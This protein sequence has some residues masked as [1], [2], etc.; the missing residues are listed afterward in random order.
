[1]ARGMKIIALVTGTLFVVALALQF[2]LINDTLLSITITLGVVFYHFAMRLFVGTGIDLIF[3]NEIDYKRA[4]F[5][6]KRFEKR[7]Y[8]ILRVRKWAKKVPTYDSDTFS[9]KKHSWEEILKAT[10]QSEI[11]HK[12]IIALSLLPILLIIP[13]GTPLVFILTSICSALFDAT[14][15]IVQRYNRPKL[16]AHVEKLN[17]RG[18]KTTLLDKNITK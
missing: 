2:I 5:K 1:M 16:L 13:F 4:C 11:V 10:C 8:S 15:V 9:P 6:E 17:S 12:T 7:L 18:A 3:H 14:F